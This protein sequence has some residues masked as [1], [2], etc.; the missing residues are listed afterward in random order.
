MSNE[1]RHRVQ[2][3]YA[4]LAAVL[5]I[6]SAH[7]TEI[8]PTDDLE[9]AVAS[10]SSGEELVLRGGR[11]FFDENVTLTANGTA[12]QPITIRAKTGDK[13]VIEQATAFHNVVEISNSS[14]VIVRGIEFTGGSHGIR[15][16]SSDFITIEDCEIQ[17]TGDVAISANAG[18]TYE[19]LKIL[20]N[21]IHHTNGTGEGMYL[22]CNNDGCRVINSL[23]E[24][25][26]IHHTNRAT[27]EQGDGIEIKEGSYGNV[28]RDNV[29]HDTKYP[30]I[31]LYSTV[32]NGPANT[33]EGNVL[34]NVSDNTIQIA[35]DAV[36]RNNIVLGNI[37]FQSHQSG[38]PSNIQLVHNT[39]INSGSGIE[40]RNVSGPVL[41]AN[42]AV[43]SQNQAIRLISGDLSQ[44]QL[45]GNVGA[46]GVSG[47]N[48]GYVDGNDITIDL[49]D[50]DYGGTPPID[51]FPS[52]G[53][54]LIHAGIAA[55]I[56]AAD[57]NGNQRNGIADAGAY[58][59]DNNGN[60]GWTIT[61]GFKALSSETKTPRPPT[62]VHAD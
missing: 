47:G 4:P 11:Y 23:I 62:N 10:L 35:A 52:P 54:A 34:W 45:F 16:M 42:N 61:S 27:V 21:H 18:G 9:A 29:I 40:V 2:W 36:V 51:A 30:G 60:P 38:S 12:A 32:G 28:I 25:N 44:V 56:T 39:V 33:I 19:G 37:S 53:S 46:G 17:E 1:N 3:L 49:V 22:G 55:Y 48:S 6:S 57:F 41:I 7:A 13:P 8:G 15:L 14:Y 59:F 50:S 5:C 20:R 43:Y 58:K 26:Y 31:I 24:G